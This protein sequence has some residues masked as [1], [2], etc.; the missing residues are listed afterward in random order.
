MSMHKLLTQ[1]SD[2]ITTAFCQI[3]RHSMN[4]NRLYLFKKVI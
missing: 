1:V 3:N 2:K 4:N